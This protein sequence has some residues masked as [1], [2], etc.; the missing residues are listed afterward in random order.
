MDNDN[1]EFDKEGKIV[2]FAVKHYI[3]DHSDKY[4][5]LGLVNIMIKLE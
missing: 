4:K 5:F 2:E 3:W 1:L